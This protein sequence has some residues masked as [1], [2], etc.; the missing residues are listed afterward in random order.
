M[1]LRLEFIPNIGYVVD[2]NGKKKGRLFDLEVVVPLGTPATTLTQTFGY[3]LPPWLIEENK[4]KNSEAFMVYAFGMCLAFLVRRSSP[5][6][7][8]QDQLLSL[9]QR[10]TRPYKNMPEQ[11]PTLLQAREELLRIFSS[12]KDVVI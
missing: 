4:N 5:S 9:V 6:L 11:R 7:M 8:V 3:L 12:K 10:M 1:H 2:Q